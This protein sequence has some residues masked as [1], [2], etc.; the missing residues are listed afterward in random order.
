MTFC[1][2]R[3]HKQK[4]MKMKN[5]ELKNK[6]T[7]ELQTNLNL[8]KATCIALIV[9]LTLLVGIT[10]YGF[11]MKDNKSTFIALFAV[12]ISCGAMLPIQFVSMKKIKTELNS[13]K[14]SE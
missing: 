4:R 8:I 13:R 6:T 1:I 11:I 5:N 12:A 2:N 3:Y 9:V 7:E 10:T 14:T